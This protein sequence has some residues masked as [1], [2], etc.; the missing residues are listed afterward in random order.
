MGEVS[1]RIEMY[2]VTVNLYNQATLDA[3]VTEA[4]SAESPEAPES[5]KCKVFRVGEEGPFFDLDTKELASK[6]VV[7]LI[8]RGYGER[9]DH[10]LDT[11][12]MTGKK[13]SADEAR[14]V[15]E[16]GQKY[17]RLGDVWYN[18]ETIMPATGEIK[19][20]LLEGGG[21]SIDPP[22]FEVSD[23]AK[24]SEEAIKLREMEQK[25]ADLAKEE[26]KE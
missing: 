4:P 6:G 13:V 8:E 12:T 3:E 10:H 26:G 19:K 25:L 14:H 11:G 9:I 15:P 2:E 22:M 16:D 7:E 23:V 24:L 18:I 1:K 20:S 21:E 5:Y 17:Y